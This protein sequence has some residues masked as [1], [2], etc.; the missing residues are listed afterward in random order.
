MIA[1]MSFLELAAKRQ[2]CRRYT[3]TEVPR[4]ALQRCVEAARLAPSA[5]NS[6]PWT[7]LVVDRDP[8]RTKVA[9][10][11]FAGIYSMNKFAIPA[12]VLVA[13]VTER[14]R[15]AAALGGKFR[16]TQFSLMDVGIAC[17]HF[18]LQAEEEGLGTC[19]LGWFDE[20][21]VKRLL[22]LSRRDKVDTLIGV[23]Y[24][25]DDTVRE[26]KRRPTEEMSRFVCDE[27]E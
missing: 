12:P 20:K 6:Q 24:P 4:E 19:W 16:G 7:F 27:G 17:E 10:A 26:K 13:V 9:Q 18:V 25:A 23:G 8:L 1:G 3:T 14:S 11:A 2:S 22:G 15:F 21:A 5:C